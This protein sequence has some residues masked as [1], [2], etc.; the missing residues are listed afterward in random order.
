MGHPLVHILRNEKDFILNYNGE[1]FLNDKSYGRLIE[2]GVNIPLI[3]SSGPVRVETLIGETIFS[4]DSSSHSSYLP[5]SELDIKYYNQQTAK[6]RSDFYSEPYD[7]LD[8]SYYTE[9]DEYI[10]MNDMTSSSPS[11]SADNSR[12]NVTNSSDFTP[13][14][15]FTDES[16]VS[17]S[18][19]QSPF[20]LTKNFYHFTALSSEGD[21]F[22]EGMLMIVSINGQSVNVQS[23]P[24][25][26]L[27]E[28]SVINDLEYLLGKKESYNSSRK[29][30]NTFSS[31]YEESEE[32]NPLKDQETSI[33]V[34]GSVKDPSV[35]VRD[36]L[37]QKTIWIKDY[38]CSYS[39]AKHNSNNTENDGS[40]T[41]IN[42]NETPVL[43]GVFSI[44]SHRSTSSREPTL[45][46]F[47][48]FHPLVGRFVDL[49]DE[50][51]RSISASP[52]NSFIEH[53]GSDG[54]PASFMASNSTL[55]LSNGGI[56]TMDHPL[57]TTDIAMQPSGTSNGS[58]SFRYLNNPG[59]SRNSSVHHRTMHSVNS[60]SDLA[61][62]TIVAHDLQDNT[63]VFEWIPEDSS[64]SMIKH[65]N[66]NNNNNNNNAN[67][68]NNG[69]SFQ[70]NTTPQC[71]SESF[72]M[73]AQLPS[74]ALSA[75]PP[76]SIIK[77]NVALCVVRE[78]VAIVKKKGSP[79]FVRDFS[80]P[81][82]PIELIFTH[83]KPE[84]QRM[85]Q[86]TG[87]PFAHFLGQQLPS[88]RRLENHLNIGSSVD[89]VNGTGIS[90]GGN[91]PTPFLIPGSPN[92]LLDPS[93][94]YP[95]VPTSRFSANTWMTLVLIF[96]GI[97]I[98]IGFVALLMSLGR[99]RKRRGFGE[100]SKNHSSGDGKNHHSSSMSFGL[101]IGGFEMGLLRD[102]LREAYDGIGE[103]I[104][105]VWMWIVRMLTV[106]LKSPGLGIKSI[107]ERLKKKREHE[108][109]LREK[110]K[111]KLQKKERIERE[112]REREE[113][114]R[115]TKEDKRKREEEKRIQ[116]E[117]EQEGKRKLEALRTQEKIRK[118]KE[119][120]KLHS[121]ATLSETESTFIDDSFLSTIRILRN[122]VSSSLSPYLSHSFLP[123][124]NLLALLSIFLDYI[125]PSS[126]SSSSAI[127]PLTPPLFFPFLLPSANTVVLPFEIGRGGGG[128]V[129]FVGMRN[130]EFVAV[131]RVIG[132]IS[133]DIHNTITHPISSST[134]HKAGKDVH[135]DQTK[136]K[137]LDTEADITEDLPLT[138]EAKLSRVAKR[139]R[140]IIAH[141]RGV[142]GIAHVHGVFPS[143]IYSYIVMDLYCVTLDTFVNV[144]FTK[145]RFPFHISLHK[146][147]MSTD[148]DV[149]EYFRETVR[150][151]LA[152]PLIM[153][154]SLLSSPPIGRASHGIKHAHSVNPM[155]LSLANQ[156]LLSLAHTHMH[157]RRFPFHISLHKAS[158][159]TDSDVYEYFRETV[160]GILA[161]PLIMGR[162]LLS[163]PPIGR[164]SHGIKHAHS[165]NPMTL[166]LANQFLLSLAHTH[167]H[168]VFP[169]GI[170]SYIVMDLYCVTLDTFVNVM[171]TKRRFPFHISL[172]KASMSTD[173]DVYE[174]FRETVRGILAEP[175]IMGRSLLSS[176]PIGRASHGIKHAHSVNPMTLSLANQ[177]LLSLAHTHMHGRRFPFHISLHK[178]SMST[179]SDVYE[180]FRETVRGILAEPLIMGRSL[181]SSPPIGRASHGIKHAH[182]VNPMTLSLANQFL[183]SL[184]HTHMHGVCHRDV[185]PQNI[186]IKPIT[187][188]STIDSHSS[189]PVSSPSS[190]VSAKKEPSVEWKLVLSD[191]G[192]SSS[193]NTSHSFSFS[194]FGTYGWRAPEVIRGEK[195]YDQRQSDIFS[196]GCVVFF[197]F[198]NHHLFGGEKE[199][200]DNIEQQQLLDSSCSSS[201]S[202]TNPHKQK[203]DSSSDSSVIEQKG[204]DSHTK[205]SSEGHES[206]STVSSSSTSSHLSP[207]L[208]L[209]AFSR[210]FLIQHPLLCD[211]VLLMTNPNPLLRPSVTQC[212][213]HP[214]MWNDRKKINLLL[215]VSEMSV[216][217][218][219]ILEEFGDIVYGKMEKY[220]ERLE[221]DMKDMKDMRDHSKASDISSPS[222]SSS[223]SASLTVSPSVGIC[224]SVVHGMNWFK[225][226]TPSLQRDIMT[227]T[228]KK[229]RR[230]NHHCIKDLI[231]YIRNKYHH[232]KELDESVQKEIGHEASEFLGY[233]SQMF[234]GSFHVGNTDAVIQTNSISIQ[235]SSSTD[236]VIQTVEPEFV[237]EGDEECCPIP[238]DAPNIKSAEFPTIKA[239]DETKEEGDEKY[240][241]SSEAQDMMTGEWN[242]GQFT[243]IS[244]PFS[245]S[246]PMKGAYICLSSYFSSDSPPSH[247][248]FT[249]TSSKGAKT[250]NTNFL[251]FNI[252]IG[253]SYLLISRML[254]CVRLQGKEGNRE[255]T[256][257]EI[258]AREAREKLWSEAPVVKAK[259]VWEG[260]RDCIPIPRDDPKVVD[261][262]FSVV[263]CKIDLYSKESKFYDLSS[264][265]QKMLKGEEFEWEE[266]D[267]W[268]DG[269]LP[270]THLSIP[271]PSPSPMKGAYICVD[272]EY[273]MYYSSLILLFTFTDCDGKKTFKKYEFT[274]PEHNYEWHFLPIDL[275]NVVLCEI[276][277]K[278]TYGEES[279]R[280][281][282]ICSLVFLRGDDIPTSP[283]LPPHLTLPCRAISPYTVPPDSVTL[284]PT[285]PSTITPQ[286]IIGSGGFGDVILAHLVSP[287]FPIPAVLCAVKCMKNA[288]THKENVHCVKRMKEEFANQC[289]LYSKPS[290]QSCIPRP[291]HML[292]FLDDDLKGTF[293]LAMEFCQGGNVMEFAKS[294]AVNVNEDE[295]EDEDEDDPEYD[296]VKIAALCVAIIECVATLFDVK[297]KLVHRDIK[298][299]NFLVRYDALKK[300]CHVLLGDL[301]FVEIRE[302]MS[303]SSFISKDSSSS[304]SSSSDGLTFEFKTSIVGTLCYSAPES[305]S[306]GF[307]CQRSDVWG[308]VLTI[309]SLFNDMKQP[310]MSIPTIRNI[311]PSPEY[312]SIL[313][314][315]LC[316]LASDP[317]RLPQL[318]DS[319]I[320]CSLET[321]E[322]G[323]YNA[324]YKAFLE[325]FHGMLN[326]NRFKRMTIHQAHS[327]TRELKHILPRV[328]EGWECP[329]IEEYIADQL[330][331]Y[332]GLCKLAS[333]PD[334]LPQLTD[335]EIFCSLETM[336]DGKYNA[337]YKAF[338][339][340][341][342]GMLNPNRFKRMTIHQAHSLTREL[343]HILPRVGEGWECPSIEEYIADQLEEYDGCTGTIHSSSSSSSSSS[344]GGK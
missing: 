98:G 152:E 248:I 13:M 243:H 166:S 86:N 301:G 19:I 89:V 342:H 207:L 112:K 194:I 325:V 41:D 102:G 80:L 186:L 136:P 234:P 187:L 319:E 227:I 154:R 146:A 290:L 49:Y 9:F 223:S 25:I 54:S 99:K 177:F 337:V 304:S 110:E 161:E 224:G 315:R 294:W 189:K 159:S 22:F 282:S 286:C 270:L 197:M 330:E 24:F 193:F 316:K 124:K 298:P 82:A 95:V 267:E 236:A 67:D 1:I 308:V 100:G 131:K 35:M 23:G 272:N 107:G 196:A 78:T 250:K 26:P 93:V 291:L 322:D 105:E 2:L 45:R 90:G 94:H 111:A 288:S 37:T 306:S 73:A 79:L 289:K 169:S 333:D 287:S 278:I 141:M 121:S 7:D 164:A 10:D 324:V 214:F 61:T 262:S 254:F 217:H 201:V 58:D 239:I 77:G 182:S 211:M 338:L 4:V 178:A 20:L 62:R 253:I 17:L 246:S 309:W 84:T 225:R 8:S 241:Q 215:A 183:L 210:K 212:L 160:R 292:D 143:G 269:V 76:F 5:I 284:T 203:K 277:G 162:S 36:T 274:Q 264:K 38:Q 170:Y 66:G 206:H 244:I 209:P 34:F 179:D 125:Q 307:Y 55:T 46:D 204:D 134:H 158:M 101:S 103:M 172:H 297:K 138:I 276:E 230:Y 190:L 65:M 295:D 16:I 255:E 81:K 332:D 42:F 283:P 299:D 60:P 314:S 74:S 29:T 313:C 142:D 213:S 273:G 32:Y 251:N 228:S 104:R 71:S 139:E 28:H 218:E 165:V 137:P 147:S 128:T 75:L 3:A 123:H 135:G 39:S 181:L 63:P 33:M 118:M 6:K 127:R 133:K 148:S 168:G 163:S 171:F 188:S 235:M 199:R 336:E 329:S 92:Q 149:Y 114:E 200:E 260:D 174:Y 108:H 113:R 57:E 68:A 126:S 249:L 275:D 96:L 320:F 144:M 265:A 245:S 259:F 85:L 192:L 229:H 233:F 232:F 220:I 56:G 261:P 132:T 303:R 311:P 91:A 185:K 302:S 43:V 119:M 252:F 340:V 51:T 70:G 318:T 205:S 198:T 216:V 122:E 334:R 47:A 328:G 129:V 130:G 202:Q 226:L 343:K 305:L 219:D 293:G 238:R 180:Y 116:L 155:T 87:L 59:H 195:I 151:I 285:S 173:S 280:F 176:P 50:E 88:I 268:E 167:M 222:V 331:E 300:Q 310:F 53:F 40:R 145:R 279:H 341:F 14:S 12:S 21:V 339:E 221:K 266:E 120:V 48:L 184:A 150:G 156:F 157:G 312:D 335:S 326:P 258:K 64:G 240:D 327:L 271:F 27:S 117:L 247:L 242:D 191:F 323:K 237:H 344:S 83:I 256:P 11:P 175:L 153:G 15:T 52:V 321:M 115:R 97:L 296:P 231:R 281:V 72:S 18:D 109:S 257:E 208:T 30:N 44:H 31:I 263:K 106:I 317:D 69:Y 140:N